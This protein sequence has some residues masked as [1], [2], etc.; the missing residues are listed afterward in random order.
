MQKATGLLSIADSLLYTHPDKQTLICKSSRSILEM[1][2]IMQVFGVLSLLTFVHARLGVATK[3]DEQTH[4][5]ADHSNWV[6]IKSN[7]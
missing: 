3:T 6:I 2:A 7:P 1:S 4:S 5:L